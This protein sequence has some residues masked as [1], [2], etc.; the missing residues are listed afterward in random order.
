MIEEKAAPPRPAGMRAQ[1]KAIQPEG[2]RV[3]LR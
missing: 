1:E 2:N 3:H